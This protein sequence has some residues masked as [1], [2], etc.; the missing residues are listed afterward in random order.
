[1]SQSGPNTIADAIHDIL[2]QIGENPD[3]EGLR[4]TPDR[5][6]Q[7]WKYWTSGYGQDPAM[8]LKTFEDGGEGYDELVFQGNIPFYSMCEHHLAPF[9]GVAH[10]AYVPD[11]RVVGLSKLGRLVDIYSRRLQT[12]ERITCQ[13]ADALMTHLNPIGVAVSL[14]ARHLCM[15][16][17]GVAKVGTITTTN[18]LRG[19]FKLNPDVRAEFM[20]LVQSQPTSGIL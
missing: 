3:R 8:I 2:H 11:G 9:F 10:I 20:S 16:S 12:Q 19:E 13:V 1:M 6:G 14:V 17:R 15:E 5:V 7:A 4:E 18:A